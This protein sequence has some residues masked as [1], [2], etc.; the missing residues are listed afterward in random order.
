MHYTALERGGQFLVLSPDA[1]WLV[2]WDDSEGDGLIWNLE[3]NSNRALI[4]SE[5]KFSADSH[6]LATNSIISRFPYL[7]GVLGVQRPEDFPLWKRLLLKDERIV[8]F[9]GNE[10]IEA[11]GEHLRRIFD[12]NSGKIILTLPLEVSRW[13]A[14]DKDDKV[15]EPSKMPF[16]V[17]IGASKPNS[18]IKST[19]LYD[20]LLLSPNKQ[21]LWVSLYDLN[22]FDILDGQTGKRLWF[23]ISKQAT[24][25]GFGCYPS[26]EDGGKSLAT[27]EN[28]TLIVRD[29]RTGNVLLSHKNNLPAPLKSWAFTKDRSAV[30]LMDNRG[31]IFR[32]RLR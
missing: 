17:P 11:Q 27:I 31:E 23:Y 14:K 25:G 30:Y 22:R 4:G 12:A 16:R 5:I 1:Q 29:A 18:L 28:D 3:T 19:C 10:R 24:N 32:Q 6:L 20:A 8:G 9:S 7:V 21:Q 13:E 26:W 15:N 2:S